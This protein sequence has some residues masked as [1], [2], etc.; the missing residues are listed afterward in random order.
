MLRGRLH[1]L[2]QVAR[3]RPL[4]AG[5]EVAVDDVV[6]S[7]S[8]ERIAKAP[9]ANKANRLQRPPTP[10]SAT[11]HAHGQNNSQVP[12]GR[13]TRISARMGAWALEAR[14]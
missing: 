4:D 14:R 3:R 2:T 1:G 8:A 5:I 13:S 6:I 9:I 12:M 7:A 10:A 11:L